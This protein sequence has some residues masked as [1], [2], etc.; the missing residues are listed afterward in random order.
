MPNSSKR[1][2]LKRLTGVARTRSENRDTLRPGSDH[3][4]LIRPNHARGE[5]GAEIRGRIQYGRAD[6]KG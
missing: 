3:R 5:T 6:H 2:G 4:A 1:L